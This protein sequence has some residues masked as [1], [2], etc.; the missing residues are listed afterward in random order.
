[1]SI[2]TFDIFRGSLNNGALWIK[3]AD[4]LSS[5]V[6]LMNECARVRP[7]RY[8]VLD[9]QASK[10]LA[11]VDTSPYLRRKPPARTSTKR[12]IIDDVA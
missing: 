12:Q 6:E 5:A 10:V 1:M 9:F 8:F 11:T 4:G 3:S 7:G 2:P